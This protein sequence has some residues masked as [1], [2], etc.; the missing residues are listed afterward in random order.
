M[1]G[2]QGLMSGFRHWYDVAGT[3]LKSFVK[4]PIKILGPTNQ[5]KELVQVEEK[6]R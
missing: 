3:K 2:F 4:G 1:I 6:K 5:Q